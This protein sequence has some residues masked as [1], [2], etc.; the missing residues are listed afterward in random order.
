MSSYLSGTCSVRQVPGDVGG[1]RV[2]QHAGGPTLCC[3]CLRLLQLGLQMV[4]P[5]RCRQRVIFKNQQRTAMP[6]AMH[7]R[8]DVAQGT[9]HLPARPRLNRW[10][11]QTLLLQMGNIQFSAIHPG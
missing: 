1:A 4:L 3:F 5:L 6:A 11:D 2:P 7:Q 8:L 9:A 10:V